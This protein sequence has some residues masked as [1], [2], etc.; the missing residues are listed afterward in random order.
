MPGN[1]SWENELPATLTERLLSGDQQAFRTLFDHFS[2][3]LMA[4]AGALLK[5]KEAAIE[6]VD[7]VFI[8]LWRNKAQAGNIDNMR[9]YLYTAVKNTALNYLSRQAQQQI[10]ASFD[11]IDI[12]LQDNYSPE[13]QLITAELF[14]KIQ[15]AVNELPPRCKMIFKLVREDGLKYREVAEIL[16]VS[17][18]T[19]DAQMVI[20]V[21][22]ISEKVKMHV[23]FLP[24][25][26]V[27]K[28]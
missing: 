17:V 27:K 7:E 20:A 22:R 6:V 12:Q 21:K 9:V 26:T 28:S 5:N 2:P 10:S 24:R 23:D 3:G 14:K 13:Q 8:K 11:H 1:T 18:N 15:S 4:F 25:V 19:V 16:N